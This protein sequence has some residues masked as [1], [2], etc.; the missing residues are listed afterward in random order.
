MC[1]S[2][3]VGV[4]GQFVGLGFL[5]CGAQ[6]VK[7]YQPCLPT[8]PS[9]WPTKPLK[10]E[11]VYLLLEMCDIKIQKQAGDVSQLEE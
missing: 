7:V 5:P 6:G 8:Q 9:Y 4:Q 10:L 1:H 3:T 2:P 11:F